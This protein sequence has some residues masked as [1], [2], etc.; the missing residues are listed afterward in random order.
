MSLRRDDEAA[1]AV[2]GFAVA[3]A[4][5]LSAVG[6]LMVLARASVP[7]EQASDA[8]PA[9]RLQAQ[10][11]LGILLTEGTSSPGGAGWDALAIAS[12]TW[13]A[14]PAVPGLRAPRDTG[15]DP[16]KVANLLQAPRATPGDGKMDPSDLRNALG[17][18]SS[19]VL[20]VRVSPLLAPLES[21]APALPFTVR[22]VDGADA[23]TAAEERALLDGLLAAPMPAGPGT[24]ITL[25]T[26]C[27]DIEAPDVLVYGTGHTDTG[28]ADAAGIAAAVACGMTLVLLGSDTPCSTCLADLVAS[29]PPASSCA[30]LATDDPTPP[31]V[32]AP[33]TLGA[34]RYAA[35]G[36]MPALGAAGGAFAAAAG[37]LP[38]PLLA[39][40]LCGSFGAGQVLVARVSPTDL[41]G[42]GR[43]TAAE[44][45][46]LL[47][48]LLVRHAQ[49]MS[50]DYGDTLPG[51]PQ[52]AP[53]QAT[54][55]G[56][57]TWPTG[58]VPVRVAVWVA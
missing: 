36:A 52:V 16:L 11:A 7:P 8:D 24:G 44:G 29:A 34:S 10:S 22:Y 14:G 21:G 20:H 31:L 50:F 26:D 1:S 43:G 4:I 9:G 58:R 51:G 57:V 46:R 2:I 37:S 54:V 53:A 55:P 39:Y 40:S 17:L 18:P 25:H 49:A 23:P 30:P 47:H 56:P 19:T 3:G 13:T 41:F 38:E 42:D 6:L 35:T 28:A 12:Q 33:N 27:S 48:N 5:F 32:T 45:A 15:L